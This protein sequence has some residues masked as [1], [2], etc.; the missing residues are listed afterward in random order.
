[1][2]S[3]D[4]HAAV[5]VMSATGFEPVRLAPRELESRALDQLGHTLISIHKNK[6][7]HFTHLVLYS[8]SLSASILK[9]FYMLII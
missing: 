5:I 8:F 6:R 9:V 3:D 1:M 2:R 7:A 4:M